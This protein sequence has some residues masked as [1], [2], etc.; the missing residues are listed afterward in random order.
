MRS[1]FLKN[2]KPCVLTA[3]TVRSYD[4]S[5]QRLHQSKPVR[6]SDEVL[7]EAEARKVENA[8]F[9]GIRYQ[10]AFARNNQ[11]EMERQVAA[12]AGEPGIEG[13]LFA[14]QAD[15]EAYHGRF[16]NAREYT[17]RAVASARHDGDE[18][19]ALS[20]AAVG[21]LREAEFGNWQLAKK[22]AGATIAHD[23]GEAGVCSWGLWRSHGRASTRKRL[24]LRAT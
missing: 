10:L 22:Q 15:T 8:F 9:P 7:S 18:E 13:W 20:Y 23:P 5:R 16:V 14:L 21:A 4:Q 2:W 19:T 6:Q 1:V 11:A 17:R 24:H 3:A 12:A